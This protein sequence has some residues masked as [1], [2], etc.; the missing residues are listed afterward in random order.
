MKKFLVVVLVLVVAVG[1][2]S[3]WRG[4]FSVTKEGKVD[5]Q[6]DSAKF[7]QDKDAF[8]KTVGEKAK[9]MKDQVA[10]LWHKSE[11]LTGDDKAHA[12]TELGELQKKHDRLEHQIKDLEDAGQERFDSIKQDLSRSLAE[13]DTKIGELTKKLD[14]PGDSAHAPEPGSSK[15]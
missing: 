13:V 15:E 3:Y 7:K 10:G 12:Q 11:S 4:W 14:H 5:V 1:V 2:L 6:V 9:A 8:S